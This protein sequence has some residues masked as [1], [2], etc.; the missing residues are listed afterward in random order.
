LKADIER[1]LAAGFNGARMHQKVFEPRYLYWA[2][3][4]GYLVWGEF[5]NW[6]FNYHP[7]NYAN[8][9]NE[10]TE[11]LQRDRNHPAIIGWCPFNESPREAGELQQII[12]QQTKAIDPTRPVLESSG[13]AHTIPRPEVLDDHDYN[14]VPANFKQR[15]DDFFTGGEALSVPARY[16]AKVA[17]ADRLGLRSRPE[18]P[19]GVLW[20]LRGAG[21]RVARQS[22]H[23][24][25]LL[26]A[27]YRRRAGAQRPVLL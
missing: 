5:P 1:S 6:G 7:E 18:R 4:L 17:P 2:D 9:I 24:R 26:H 25:L 16:G 15:W 21:G 8:Y 20:P 3:Q 12:W 13:W 10:W 22:K 14:Q 27:A 11:V 23:V 19:R